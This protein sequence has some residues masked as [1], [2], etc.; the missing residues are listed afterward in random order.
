MSDNTKINIIGI[1]CLVAIIL[2]VVALLKSG[3]QGPKGDQGR[4]GPKGDPGAQGMRGLAGA[5]G[6]A[7]TMNVVCSG[8]VCTGQIPTSLDV[9]GQITASKVTSTGDITASGDIVQSPSGLAT[10]GKQVIIKEDG[11]LVLEKGSIA[12]DAPDA[13]ITVG[14]VSTSERV[15]GN[16]IFTKGTL[17]VVDGTLYVGSPSNAWGPSGDISNK[18]GSSIGMDIVAGGQRGMRGG[19][20]YLKG[21]NW[22]SASDYTDIWADSGLSTSGNIVIASPTAYLGLGA[23][24]ADAGGAR[25]HKFYWDNSGIQNG[26]GGTGGNYWTSYQ[27]NIDGGSIVAESFTASAECPDYDGGSMHGP[28]NTTA[29]TC[30]GMHTTT[31]AA[32]FPVVK[33]TIAI[34]G[35]SNVFA[36]N[37]MATDA[38]CGRS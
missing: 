36:W 34:A 37:C 12:V 28:F 31:N 29:M 32:G 24:T 15:V 14:D 18:Y 26:K 19:G 33:P 21:K 3:K 27:P 10:F 23:P 4:Q 16:G 22:A 20:I 1:L 17:K 7:G 5:T 38:N 13:Y 8:E 25:P 11:G 9:A 6:P 2:A 35:M 30:A